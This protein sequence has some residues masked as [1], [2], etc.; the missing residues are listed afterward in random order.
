MNL[1]LRSPGRLLRLLVIPGALLKKMMP[2]KG[3]T[4]EHR[5]V[6]RIDIEAGEQLDAAR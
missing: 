2:A 4:A 6:R 3:G 5:P 1:S